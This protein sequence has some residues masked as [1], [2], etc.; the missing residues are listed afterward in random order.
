MSDNSELN[1]KIFAKNLNYYMTT[2]N[3]TQS[4]LV[5]DLNLTASTVSDWANGKKYPRVDKMQLL[6][7]YFGI[8]KSDLT[9]EHET[10]KMTDDI[11]LQEYLEELKNRSELRMLFSLTKGATKEDVEK[12]VR[13]IEAL[14]KDE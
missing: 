12:A 8:L 14:K 11:E 4:D 3:K 2:N 13:I 5:T 7:D 1:K 6:A 10:S 9:E